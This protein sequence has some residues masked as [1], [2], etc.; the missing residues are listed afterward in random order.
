[1]G[2]DTAVYDDRLFDLLRT[3]ADAGLKT[4]LQQK[5]KQQQQKGDTAAELNV[6]N[7]RTTTS[8]SAWSIR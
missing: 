3:N 6:R 5:Q 1:M 8:S 7:Y 4:K 2:S